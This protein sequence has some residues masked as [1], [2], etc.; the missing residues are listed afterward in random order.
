MKINS[1]GKNGMVLVLT[2]T[3]LALL[4]AE[5]IFLSGFVRDYLDEFAQERTT[6]QMRQVARLGISMGEAILRNNSGSADYPGQPWAVKK[7]ADFPEGRLTI[8]IEDLDGRLN[9]NAI[10]D[11]KG[12]INTRYLTL[13]KNL[14][15]ECG[16]ST[17]LADVLMDWLDEDDTPRVFGAEDGF[18]RSLSPPYRPAN[19]PIT[20]IRQLY[21]LK[22]WTQELLEGDQQHTGLLYLLTTVSDSKINPNTADAAVLKALG[23]SDQVTQKII[24]ERANRPLTAGILASYDRATTAAWQSLLTFKSNYFLVTARVTAPDLKK[25]VFCAVIKRQGNRTSIISLEEQ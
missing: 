23:Y 11:S 4:S 17:D 8:S 1:G 19:G 10:L 2:L 18:Y 22:G 16:A 12:N 13:L 5:A 3:F 14:L 20:N 21:F 25:T 15:I 7:I 9:L 6:Q 24:D